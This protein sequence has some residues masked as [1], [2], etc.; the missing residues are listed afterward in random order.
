[1]LVF[2]NTTRVEIRVLEASKQQVL[3]EKPAGHVL[4]FITKSMLYN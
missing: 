2:V 1:M 4:Q 3:L